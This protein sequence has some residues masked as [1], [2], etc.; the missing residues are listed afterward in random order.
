ML[1]FLIL[2][3]IVFEPYTLPPEE[4]GM[5]ILSFD[6]KTSYIIK[7]G[8]YYLFYINGS[9]AFNKDKKE[10]KQLLK[11]EHFKDMKIYNKGEK[12]CLPNKMM[13]RV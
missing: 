1:G 7:D 13:V 6:P 5:E 12:N 3:S 2:S 9:L 4:E 11:S 10:T 8:E